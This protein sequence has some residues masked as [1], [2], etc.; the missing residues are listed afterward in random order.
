M[1]ERDERISGTEQPT[2]PLPSESIMSD[3]SKDPGKSKT[4]AE[5]KPPQPVELTDEQLLAVVGGAV[6][7]KPPPTT[8]PGGGGG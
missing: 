1:G 3:K 8:L 4:E 2:D 7:P 6:N 5:K